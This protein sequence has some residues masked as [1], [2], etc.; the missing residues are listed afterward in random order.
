MYEKELKAMIEVSYLAGDNIMNY[1]KN[2]FHTEF[3]EDHSPVTEA[4]K[5][6]DA[7]IR[8]YLGNLFLDYS[9]LTE[10]SKDDKSRL[11]N[12]YVFIVDPLDGTEDFVHKDGEFTVNIALCHKHEIV[13][14]VIEVPLTREVYYAIKGEGAYK[15]DK[16]GN[17]TRLH[18]SN[19]TEDLTCFTSVYHLADKEIE[20]IK[21]HSD[22]I[23]H[24]I[25]K[26]SSLK[27]CSIAEGKGEISYR[28]TSGTKERDTAAFDLI[29]SE[30][31]GYVIKLDGTKMTYNREDVRNLDPYV[32]VNKLE[33][34]LL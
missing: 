29:V 8:N 26:G 30:S 4:D 7:L 33:N 9:F 11:K 23:K 3:K 28:L 13:V 34:I 32:V 2:G 31:G 5:T 27:G 22:K 17:K 16:N 10:E 21:K 25:K 18:V 24:V 1:Y 15:I 12:D 14:G 20:V 6:S 19:K